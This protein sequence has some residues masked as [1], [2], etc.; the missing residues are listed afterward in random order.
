MAISGIWGRYRYFPRERGIL[1]PE[2][3]VFGIGKGG[4]LQN[5][6]HTRFLCPWTV[7]SGV[8]ITPTTE[9]F[10]EVDH[11]SAY[12][13]GILVEHRGGVSARGWVSLSD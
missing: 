1:S 11:Y 5:H 4:T 9:A 7:L 3:C 2:R 10:W 6:L 8:I 12:R 13:R